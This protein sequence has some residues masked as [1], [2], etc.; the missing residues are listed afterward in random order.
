MTRLSVCAIKGTRRL[1]ASCLLAFAA[2]VVVHPAQAPGVAR[3]VAIGDVHGAAAELE[4]VLGRAGLI[5]ADGRWSGGRTTLVQTGDVVD[6]GSQVRDALDL[7]ARLER[8]AS[9]AGGRV[10]ALVGNHEVMAMVGEVRDATPQ[11]FVT[12]ADAKSEERREAG[13]RAFTRLARSRAGRLPTLPAV[14][15]TVSKEAWLAAH[16]PGLIEY[17]QAFARGGSYGR[18]LRSRRAV[19]RVGDTIFLHGG[20]HPDVAR[21]KIDDINDRIARELAEFDRIREHLLERDV[22]LPF[23]TFMEMVEAAKAE[24][25]LATAAAREG[26]AFGEGPDTHYPRMLQELLSM[27]NWWLFHSDGPLWFRGYAAWT[28]EEGAQQIAKILQA[29]GAKRIV[30]GHTVFPT[31]RITPRFGGRVFLIDTGMLAGTFFPNGRGSALQIQ[32][33]SVTA[34]YEDA[35]VDLTNPSQ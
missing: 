21:F 33:S 25:P 8:E 34:I 26:T 30:V 7:L 28:P 27:G 17:L 20:I 9:S 18:A 15:Q 12:F 2:S 6:R 1:L 29:F 19:A 4:R 16:P 35:P 5:D 14:Y 10:V 3:V 32:G 23:F 22:I 13:Y 11:I 31:T 24:L